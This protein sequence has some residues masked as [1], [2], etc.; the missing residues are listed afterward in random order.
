MAQT[1]LV[2]LGV[3]GRS[4]LDTATFS[5]APQLTVETPA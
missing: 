4:G 5:L 1:D 3:R 2:I